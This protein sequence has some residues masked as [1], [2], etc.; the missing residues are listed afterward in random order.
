MSPIH[1]WYQVYVSHLQRRAE[2][3]TNTQHTKPAKLRHYLPGTLQRFVKSGGGRATAR[4]RRGREMQL[5]SKYSISTCSSRLYTYFSNY[6]MLSILVLLCTTNASGGGRAKVGE[7]RRASDMYVP[8]TQ[9]YSSTCSSIYT[10][11][12]IYIYNISAVQ[13]QY[14][15]SFFYLR[16]VRIFSGGERATAGKRRHTSKKLIP[17]KQGKRKTPDGILVVDTRISKSGSNR[18]MASVFDQV[19]IDL[20][21]SLVSELSLRGCVKTPEPND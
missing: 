8:D 18:K 13:H 19:K 3:T 6:M 4:E 5:H 12:G 20:G 11:F 1:C 10:F 17:V 15:I 21:Q 14:E 16:L 7:R 9:Q 2:S